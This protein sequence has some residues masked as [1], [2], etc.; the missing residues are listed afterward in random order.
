MRRGKH[1]C[2][3]LLKWL[4][5]SSADISYSRLEPKLGRILAAAAAFRAFAPGAQALRSLFGD[6]YDE[7]GDE[8]FW[9]VHGRLARLTGYTTALHIM[10][11]LG[12]N[13][14]KP[15]I[16]LVR[17]M[18]RLGWIEDALPANSADD[19]IR[20]AY[21]KP[22]IARVVIGRA[23]QIAGHVHAWNKGSPLR[24]FDFV[25]VKYGQKPGEF[26]IVRSLHEEWLPVERIMEWKS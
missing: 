4:S 21:Q 20:K 26:G 3:H 15:D 8:A 16:W 9:R 7:P 22:S 25:M 17:L 14:V 23:R 11:D 24:E 19:A 10:T 13:C 5:F 18:C 12:F 1:R 6:S 2:Q